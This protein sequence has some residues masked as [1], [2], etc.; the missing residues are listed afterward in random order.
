M[1][2]EEE[3]DVNLRLDDVIVAILPS[4]E[5]H[6]GDFVFLSHTHTL[7]GYLLEAIHVNAQG[8]L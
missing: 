3:E 8:C 7:V 2:E 5:N 1:E 6:L 4:S